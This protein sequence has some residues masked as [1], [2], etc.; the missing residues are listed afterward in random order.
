MEPLRED[1]PS[2]IGRYRLS[3]RLGIGAAG[4]V[5]LAHT[6][7]GRP[8]AVKTIHPH[9]VRDRDFPRRFAREVAAARA[10]GGFHTAALIDAGRTHT[11]AW[12][13]TEY[14]AAPSLRQVITR[15]GPL[16]ENAV[17]GI[18][19]GIAEALARIHAAG[20]VHR[21]LKPSNVLVTADGPRVIDFGIAA[22]H[23]DTATALGTPGFMAPE[24]V[25]GGHIGPATDMF[26]LGALLVYAITGR[27]PFGDADAVALLHRAAAGTADLSGV[28]DGPLLRLASACLAREP[29]RRPVPGQVLAALESAADTS[30]PQAVRDHVRSYDRP[31]PGAPVR[32]R[33]SRRPARLIGAL[34]LVLILVAATGVA[35]RA[36]REPVSGLAT[37]SPTLVGPAR[38][39][40][41]PT[42]LFGVLHSLSLS[43]DGRE[44]FVAY[45]TGVRVI[46]TVTDQATR[47][48]PVQSR[49]YALM[50]AD[51]RRVYSLS[52]LADHTAVHDAASGAKIAE[53]PVDAA[54][55]AV[56]APPGTLMYLESRRRLFAV[57]TRGDTVVGAPIEFGFDVHGYASVA[58]GRKLYVVQSVGRP[59]DQQKTLSVLDTA[60]ATVRGP[61]AFD[62]RPGAIAVS[63]NG[64][65]AGVID[66]AGDRL[67]VLDTETDTVLGSVPLGQHP[68]EV[69]LSPDGARAYLSVDDVATVI[70]VDTVSFTVLDRIRVARTP[71]E[72]MVSPDG[73][74]LY[75][76]SRDEPMVT[77]VPLD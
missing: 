51:G 22:I 71:T 33:R 4:E 59:I 41:I 74:R 77:V 28:P 56:P 40:Q 14:V 46:D 55:F 44:L 60:T 53:I 68:S 17:V 58:G 72:L 63:A 26:S 24:Q 64:L 18:G 54:T 70:V 42:S 23:G 36:A 27:G 67:C 31:Q 7:G 20:V 52:W 3:A 65:R 66:S 30:L 2:T 19:R 37:P 9:L 34:A 25:N 1:D 50:S 16:P 62:G 29:A 76:G 45:S 5:Y 43:P 15:H 39:T 73:R 61:I 12:L 11:A 6:P 57:D 32:P 48:I 75:V 21:D 38:P 49:D 47:T 13:V 10:V 69:A 35:L 8:V